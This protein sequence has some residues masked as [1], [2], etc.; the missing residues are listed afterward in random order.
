MTVMSRD[1]CEFGVEAFND[2][3]LGRFEQLLAED[4]I[5][6]APGVVGEGKAAC[7]EFYRRWFDDFPDARL[8]VR[9]I[10][11]V[12]DVVVE[13]G[14]CVGTHEGVGRTGRTVAVDYV[15]VLRVGDGKLISFTLTFDRLLMLEQLGL[16]PGAGPV[17]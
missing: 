1:V 5:F 7:V 10:H 11:L 3:D 8:E 16:I 2:H 9:K 6:R 12:G 17:G 14:T 13:E 15:Q 4:V